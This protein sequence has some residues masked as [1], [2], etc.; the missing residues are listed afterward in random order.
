MVDIAETKK[1]T[2]TEKFGVLLN[3]K[4]VAENEMLVEFINKEVELLNK[5]NG[6]NGQTK[7][8][9]ENE[10]YK[11]TIVEI[12]T[13]VGKGLT[14]SEIQ[15]EDETLAQFSNQK[16]SALLTQL[17]ND[18]IVTRTKDKKITTFAIAE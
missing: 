13:R 7:G 15:A 9:K 12:L 14:I 2:K 17:V 8:Q 1:L 10:G 6:K 5:K 3:I 18:K 16:I 4:E 11:N